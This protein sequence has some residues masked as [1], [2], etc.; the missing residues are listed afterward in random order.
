MSYSIAENLERALK[1]LHKKGGRARVIAGGTDLFLKKPLPELVDISTVPEILGIYRDEDMLAI[2]AGVTH[3][4]AAASDIIQF[5]AEALAE[6]CRLVGSPQVRNMGTL[7]GNVV[8][9]APAADAAVALV[10]L[11]AKAVLVNLEGFSREAAVEN[12]YAGYNRSLVDGTSEILLRFLMAPAGE[13]R[14]SAFL[15]FAPR[16]ALSLP[17]VNSAACVRLRDNIIQ[18]VRVVIAPVKPAPTRLIETEKLLLGKTPGPG[19]WHKVE[20]TAASETEVRGSLLRCSGEYRRHLVGILARRV[21]KKAVERALKN[22]NG[23]E[24]S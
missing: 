22:Q 13:G 24:S 16:E 14:G 4:E 21:L 6:A 10:A 12:L 19:T 8:N 5:E 2:G 20:F 23:G 3:S 15:R 9:A 18:E 17:L 1:I 11:G 7:G